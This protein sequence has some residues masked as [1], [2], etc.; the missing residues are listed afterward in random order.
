MEKT[1]SKSELVRQFIAKHPY[2][3]NAAVI[4]GLKSEGVEVTANL[5]NQVRH[6]YKHKKVKEVQAVVGDQP[7]LKVKK[8]A[9]EVGGIDNLIR[10]AFTIK[11]LFGGE[12]ED[13]KTEE[14]IS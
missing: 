9:D 13:G 6:D 4:A 12:A 3:D 10:L 5:V 14:P 1:I 11:Q 8:L 7:I 2:T